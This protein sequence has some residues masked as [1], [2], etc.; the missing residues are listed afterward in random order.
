MTASGQPSGAIW[1]TDP[2]KAI[3]DEPRSL[4]Q[5]VRTP[6]L[7]NA[8]SERPRIVRLIPDGGVPRSVSCAD[9][10]H[11][12]SRPKAPARPSMLKDHDRFD[13]DIHAI[14]LTR[15]RA[16]CG[17]TICLDCERGRRHFRR[18]PS[19]SVALD[20]DHGVK[21]DDPEESG[22]ASITPFKRGTITCGLS[23]G[24]AV[25]G[26]TGKCDDARG[27]PPIG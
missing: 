23:S 11:R 26:E 9:Q 25:Y 18:R 13:K 4:A 8:T 2:K 16:I 3:P 22:G 17:E 27:G 20:K 21:P 10:R 12:S 15:G 1:R 7:R 6:R 5:P 19:I 14:G 24:L